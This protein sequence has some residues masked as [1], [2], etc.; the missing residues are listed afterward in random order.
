MR[1]FKLLINGKLVSGAARLDVIN[2]AKIE[3]GTVWIN[4]FLDVSPDVSFG[5][6]KQSGIGAELGQEGLEAFTQ[7]K[8]INMAK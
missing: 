2:P 1:E 5:G 7:I 8:I 6:A 4:K 3:T